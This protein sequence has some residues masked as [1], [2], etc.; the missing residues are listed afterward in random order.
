MKLRQL[1]EDVTPD[2]VK[3]ALARAGFERLGSAFG[4]AKFVGVDVVDKIPVDLE[5]VYN[6]E[7]GSW[8][9][10]AAKAGEKRVEITNGRGE[11]DLIRHIER[12]HRLKA[13][14]L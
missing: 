1:H 2:D 5:Y 10:L 13:S 8:S 12:K 7:T 11:D 6:S 3:R 4:D 9:F 14:Q